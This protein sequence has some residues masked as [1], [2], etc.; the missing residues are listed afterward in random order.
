MT[1][2]SASAR[3]VKV[4]SWFSIES[5]QKNFARCVDRAF[6]TKIEIGKFRSE[7]QLKCARFDGFVVVRRTM[8]SR[9]RGEQL[10]IVRSGEWES[11]QS[12]PASALNS[13]EMTRP[14]W[15]VEEEMR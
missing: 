15:N 3:T 12:K 7:I 13:F 11:I 1:F 5:N 10:D 9:G 4:K 2:Q 8:T 14:P 6:V